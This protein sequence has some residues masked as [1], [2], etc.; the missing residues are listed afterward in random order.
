MPK[1]LFRSQRVIA[2]H[3][4]ACLMAKD[5]A[6]ES[7][8]EREKLQAEIEATVADLRDVSCANEKVDKL[9]T[10]LRGL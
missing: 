8:R 3:D 2:E 9:K 1:K 6:E 7:H 4:K 10:L 5:V